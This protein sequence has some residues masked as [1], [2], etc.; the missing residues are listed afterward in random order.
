M[1]GEAGWNLHWPPSQTEA[2]Q[3][4]DSLAA[5]SLT[6]PGSFSVLKAEVPHGISLFLFYYFKFIFK[7]A[8]V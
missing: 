2:L 4:R 8:G 5:G 3:R 6:Q 1:R 7:L